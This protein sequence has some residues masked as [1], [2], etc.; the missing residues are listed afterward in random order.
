[1]HAAFA[2]VTILGERRERAQGV[3]AV[4]NLTTGEQQVLPRDAVAAHITRQIARNDG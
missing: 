3:V 1:M 4:K 2:F